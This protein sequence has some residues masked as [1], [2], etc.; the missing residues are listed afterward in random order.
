MLLSM[1]KGFHEIHDLEKV[2]EPEIITHGSCS[3]WVN[4]H[5]FGEYC[6]KH[7]GKAMF[8]MY[9]TFHIELACLLI[10]DESEQYTETTAAYERFVN[11]FGPDD[12]NSI[13]RLTYQHIS[14]LTLLELTAIIRLTAYD[15]TIFQ[16]I[17]PRLRQV[18]SPLSA[19]DRRR[20]AQTMHK[21]W[22]MY[23]TIFESFDMAYELGGI[24]YDL[25]YYPEA[26]VYFKHSERLFGQKADIYYNAALCHYQ[27]REDALF[28]IA[29]EE[30]RRLFPDFEGFQHLDKLDLAAV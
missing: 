11:D 20:F 26:L 15:S 29:L 7:G 8:P 21:V 6:K 27:L 17:L 1:D 18:I 10:V 23:F 24:F 22:E 13:K 28:T 30:G 12:L 14:K 9:S 5:A 16:N 25:G 4:Y 19:N 3:V 2:K